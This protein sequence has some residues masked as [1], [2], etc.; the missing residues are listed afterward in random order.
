MTSLI[1]QITEIDSADDQCLDVNVF[2][3]GTVENVSFDV[4][5]NALSPADKATV[6]NFRAL[7]ISLIPT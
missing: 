1:G 5:Y 2:T 4:D 3:L 7:M 6:D